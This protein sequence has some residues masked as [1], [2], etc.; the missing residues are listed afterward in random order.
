MSALIAITGLFKKEIFR[1]ISSVT[2][3]K[4]QNDRSCEVASK[5][6][7]SLGQSRKQDVKRVDRKRNLTRKQNK[8]GSEEK[9]GTSGQTREVNTVDDLALQRIKRSNPRGQIRR[10]IICRSVA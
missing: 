6:V 9:K 2:T 8:K 1:T 4:T 5:V 3:N 7:K 10:Q